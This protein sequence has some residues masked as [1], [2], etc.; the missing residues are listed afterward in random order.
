MCG[1]GLRR[2]LGDGIS[3]RVRGCVW[4]WKGGRCLSNQLGVREGEWRGGFGV[5]VGD[6]GA[7]AV[8]GGVVAAVDVVDVGVDRGA[9]FGGGS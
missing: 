8:V 9:G 6:D 4:M 1:G 2:R 3:P 7:A 5:G